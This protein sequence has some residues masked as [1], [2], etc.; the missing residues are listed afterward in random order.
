MRMLRFFTLFLLCIPLLRAQSNVITITPTF[1]TIDVPG[2]VYTGI[3]G[4]NAA[5][6]MTGNYGQNI[7][8]D[9]HGFTYDHGTFTYF[10]YPGESVT[11]PLGIN[12]SNL[13]VGYAGKYTIVGFLYDGAD[14]TTV[15]D[16]IDSATYAQ[17]I[18][19]AGIVVGGVGDIYT[20]KG[21]EMRNGHFKGL[22]VQGSYT[23]VKGSGIN[24]F[25]TVVGWA[26]SEGFVCKQNSCTTLNYPGAFQTSL[27]GINDKGII[28]GWYTDSTCTCGFATKNGK[29]ISFGFPGAA[30]TAADSVNSSGQIV[31]QYT[32]DYS[33]YHGFITNPITDA[34]FQ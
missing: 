14:F 31:G 7:L 6:V 21:F 1:T 32:F 30:G 2:A 34:D 16:G 22:R 26:D 20:T 18:N 33:A 29:F 8:K 10:D 19:N 15:T 3:F 5:G 12:D 27:R 24:N 25:G 13:I 11:V 28:V 23:Y 17:G 4:I 9:S